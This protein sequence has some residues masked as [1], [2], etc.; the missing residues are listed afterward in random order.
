[1]L[2]LFEIKADGHTVVKVEIEIEKLAKLFKGEINQL[3]TM[4]SIPTST[5]MTKL[6][7]EELLSKV[8]PKS[9]RFLRQIAANNGSISWDA[10]R[11]IFGIAKKDDWN[12]YALSYGRGITRAFRHLLQSKSARLVWWIDDDWKNEPWG[13][14]LVAV[15][16]DG[17]ALKAL[18]EAAP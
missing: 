15:Y 13:S 2:M 11:E 8:D 10:M 7:A 14:D 3:Q 6:Q 5:P 1:M 16:I 17:P 4:A 9:A 12:A 18:Q